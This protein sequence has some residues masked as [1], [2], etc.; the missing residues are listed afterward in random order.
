MRA[1]TFFVSAFAAVAFAQDESATSEAP[2]VS[3]VAT[4]FQLLALPNIEQSSVDAFPQTT[5][6]Q[7]TNS[8]GVVTGQP[9]VETSQPAAA[10][11]QPNQPA[12]DTS[13]PA[14]ATS[15]PA[16][17]SIPAV[18]SGIHTVVVPLGNNSTTQVVVSANNST[19]ITYNAPTATG[20]KTTGGSGSNRPT[21]TS[22][23]DES[24]KPTGTGA[25]Q[26]GATP[27]SSNAPGAAANVQVAAGMIGA[28]LL[29][30]FL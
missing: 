29:A 23:S 14:V 21:G 13:I 27:S 7:Q 5:F 19:T 6:L 11:S 17:I 4:Q 25:E 15:L 1:A 10:S 2:S 26:T 16:V 12:V 28:G 3:L 22:G 18:G 9:N 24:D 20:A 30:A 8:L